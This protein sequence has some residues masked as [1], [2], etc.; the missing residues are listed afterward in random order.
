MITIETKSNQM[1]R[2][3][4][5]SSKTALPQF[6]EPARAR[7]VSKTS[8]LIRFIERSKLK[9]CCFRRY[10]STLCTMN[11]KTRLFFFFAKTRD[12]IMSLG[13]VKKFKKINLLTI[14]Q[15]VACNFQSQLI[16]HTQMYNLST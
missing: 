5:F 8:P 1:T 9:D 14:N 3:I 16:L 12:I 4:K 6:T 15:R 11:R 13:T 7:L 10:Y 2:S